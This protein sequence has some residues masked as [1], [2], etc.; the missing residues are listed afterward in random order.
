[1]NRGERADTVLERLH[2]LAKLFTAALACVAAF[3]F[4]PWFVP[5]AFAAA[6]ALL[7]RGRGEGPARLG[8][9]LRTFLPFAVIIVLANVFLAGHP[10]PW[11][12]GAAAGLVQSLRVLS[13]IV[14][15]NLFL[16][17]TDPVDLS[18]AL[19][20]SLRPLE[21]TGLRMGGISLMVM[22]VASFVPL[23]VEEARRLEL[24][25]AARCGFPRRGPAAVRAA[26]P[27]LAP[28]F[29]GVIRRADEIDLALRAR[30]F[31]LDA[32]RSALRHARPGAADYAA[33]AAAL[34]LF[35][36]GVYAQF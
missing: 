3:L 29:A 31:R 27:L 21:R 7:H 36:A 17:V 25:Q 20:R 5:T 9:V 14:V 24:A 1:M 32:P 28:L 16:A 12:H 2:P 30:A 4:R 19:A 23:M 13:M 8:A 26:A 35:L 15:V 22:L 34:C 10:G 33:V 6:A 11:W 18:D